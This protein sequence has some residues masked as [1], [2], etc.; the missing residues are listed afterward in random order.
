MQAWHRMQQSCSL[1]ALRAC[2]GNMSTEGAARQ[3]HTLL[4]LLC[5][6]ELPP[7]HTGGQVLCGALCACVGGQGGGAGGRGGGR[8]PRRGEK[9]RR[10][11]RS[12]GRNSLGE[13][14]WRARWHLPAPAR[15]RSCR[16]TWSCTAGPAACKV[17]GRGSWRTFVAI[18][19][20]AEVKLANQAAQNVK[21]HAV[22]VLEL[23]VVFFFALESR[24]K[25]DIL[26]WIRKWQLLEVSR[27]G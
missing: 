13:R 6:P 17:L 10:G 15:S 18:A 7:L 27:R 20:Q 26:C 4:T 23:K 21:G 1:R 12:E 9:E 3:D 22:Q 24:N 2:W 16:A 11:S 25:R 8:A 19:L 14:K 5:C